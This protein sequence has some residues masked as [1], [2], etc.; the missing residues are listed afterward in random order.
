MCATV[1]D[2]IFW[3]GAPN[4]ILKSSRW[5]FGFFVVTRVF[6]GCS[7]V[8]ARPLGLMFASDLSTRPVHTKRFQRCCQTWFSYIMARSVGC[9]QAINW[10][11]SR[12]P[13]VEENLGSEGC[14]WER[15]SA[16]VRAVRARGARGEVRECSAPTEIQT[17]RTEGQN[18]LFF[19][20]CSKSVQRRCAPQLKCSQ[21]NNQR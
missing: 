3:G 13:I 1:A 12:A 9:V 20:F 2:S 10:W 6:R 21:L 19:R 16:E 11:R 7:A 17:L 4:R 8:V 15:C 5:C 14:G 18:S